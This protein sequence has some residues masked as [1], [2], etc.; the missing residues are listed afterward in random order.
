VKSYDLVAEWRGYRMDLAELKLEIARNID[1]RAA[2]LS[3]MSDAIFNNPEQGYREF[4]ACGLLADFLRSNG[5]EVEVGYAGLETAFRAVLKEGDGGPDIGMLCEYDALPMGHACAHHLQGPGC[6]GAALAIRDTVRGVPYKIEVIGTPAEE[7]GEGGKN[8]ML[9]NG[10]FTGLDV[11]MMLHGGDECTTDVKSIALT[12]L[13]VSYKGVSSHSA[14]A[15]EDG[16]SA[17]DALMLASNGLAYLRGH[18]R[19]DVRMSLIVLEGGSVINAVPDRAAVRVELRSYSRPYLDRLIARVKAVFE[20]AAMMTETSCEIKKDG[21]MHN[22]IP[23]MALNDMMMENARLI[24][25]RQISSPRE[26]TGSTDFAS[27]MRLVPGA[28]IRVALADR[29][30][31]PHSIEFLNMGKTPDAHKAMLEASKII[32]MTCADILID[33]QNLQDIIRDFERETARERMEGAV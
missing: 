32:A 24:G 13:V 33:P 21:D 25:A 17:L 7:V 22:K 18:V 27:V 8:V 31:K 23:V 26:K 16:R 20:G 28:C 19:E 14:I 12:E 15:P 9:R 11:A 5:F 2:E 29:G 10:A 30:V 1:G 4:F 6:I 3:E